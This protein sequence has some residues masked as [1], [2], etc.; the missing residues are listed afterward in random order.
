MKYSAT[1]TLSPLETWGFGFSGHIAWVMSVPAI[2]A[3]L[4]LS[5][6]YIW[7]P[8][9][10]VAMI[11]CFQVFQ[12]GKLFPNVNSSIPG[13]LIR[14]IPNKPFFALFSAIGYLLGWGLALG[15]YSQLIVDVIVRN[16]INLP[17]LPSQ[18]I[19]LIFFVLIGFVVGSTSTKTVAILNLIF[20][21]PTMIMLLG[22]GILGIYWLIT[23]PGSPGLIP[24]SIPSLSIPDFIKWIFYM[25]YTVIVLDTVAIFTKDSQN[26]KKTLA[27]LPFSALFAPMLFIVNSFVIAQTSTSSGSGD[28]FSTFSSSASLLLGSYG[29]TFAI[30]LI[31]LCNLLSGVACI[32]ICT[33]VIY[34]FSEVGLFHPIFKKISQYGVFTN[35]MWMTLVIGLSSLI[36]K[37]VDQLVTAAG[38]ANL[39]CYVVFNGAI[40]AKRSLFSSPLI[41]FLS[42]GISAFLGISLAGGIYLVNPFIIPIAVGLLFLPIVL[43]KLLPYFNQ[44]IKRLANYI[45]FPKVFRSINFT[46]VQILLI[47]MVVCITIIYTY[48]FHTSYGSSNEL[49]L[50]NGYATFFIIFSFIGTALAAWT[51]IPQTNL[52]SIANNQVRETN[53]LLKID[54]KK[55]KVLENQLQEMLYQDYLTGLGN[56]LF[57][58]TQIQELVAQKERFSVL[59][60]D[61][62]RFK[63]VNDTFGHML[64]DEILILAS[65]RLKAILPANC[66]LGRLGG[67]EFVII[68]K[69]KA[70]QLAIQMAEEI[71]NQFSKPFSL[72]ESTILITAS[73]GIVNVN[74]T[75]RKPETIMRSADLAMYRT[76]INGRNGFTLY[77]K[78]MYKDVSREHHLETNLRKAIK[79]HSGFFIEYQPIYSIVESRIVGLEALV[80]WQIDKNTIL[81]PVDFLP[82]AQSLSLIDKITEEVIQLVSQDIKKIQ[83]YNE[84]YPIY[85]SINCPEESLSFAGFCKQILHTLQANNIPTSR[86]KLEILENS[87]M[88]SNSAVIS[89]IEEC[90]EAGIQCVID[91][92]GTG[93]SNFT[94]LT[95]LPF[96]QIKID[97]SLVQSKPSTAL[98]LIQSIRDIARALSLTIVAEG[99]E[100]KEQLALVK[101]LGIEYI[102]GYYISRPK[103][104]DKI[105]TLIDTKT[106]EVNHSISDKYSNHI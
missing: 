62:D 35:A 43:N 103:R 13:Y 58:T 65:L 23:N 79:E 41:P 37:N 18:S 11:T 33:R 61:L 70:I 97:K 34:Q 99:V 22:F 29:S 71:I 26:P 28:I 15:F 73:I 88:T 45:Y 53:Q 48:S 102:Q 40:W 64:G 27:F 81:S 51:T 3:A 98:K 69:D 60:I 55:R 47:L 50:V 85:I 16:F 90:V 30:V 1:R 20:I 87:A 89:T 86:I 21:I 39:F 42:L 92:F 66:S 17:I 54:I 24:P 46:F 91:D 95:T 75:Y 105:I 59:F 52:V 94:R 77:T 96:S 63:V 67:D 93:Y 14:L 32:M 100:T 2:H 49:Q 104:I 57:V 78:D 25:S 7:I 5:S 38:A 106:F 9:C 80:R 6:M 8:L 74:K 44:L 19:L 31:L 68:V 83:K 76:K 12:L 10:I 84:D 36:F 101:S 56:R 82:I 72:K 4:G